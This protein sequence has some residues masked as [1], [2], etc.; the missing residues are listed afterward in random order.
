MSQQWRLAIVIDADG[1]T[2]VQAID[3][4]SGSTRDLSAAQAGAARSSAAMSAASRRVEGDLQGLA[5]TARGLAT[6]F[7]AVW[8]AQTVRDILSTTTRIDGMRRTLEGVLGGS[9]QAAQGIAFV[10][11]EASR[12]GVAFDSS[13]AGYTRLAAAAK[14]TALSGEVDKLASAVIQAGRAFNLS[15]DEISGALT[16]IEQ[17]ISKGTVSAEELRGQLGERLVGSFQVAAQAMGGTTAELSK[18]LETGQVVAEDFLPKFA[19]ALSASTAAAAGLN[20]S[21]PAAEFARVRNELQEMSTQL[22]AGIFEGLGDGLSDLVTKLQQLNATEIGRGIGEFLGALAANADL[23]LVAIVALVGARGIGALITALAGLRTYLAATALWSGWTAGVTGASGALTLLATRAGALVGLLGGIPGVIALVVTGLYALATA[24]SAAEERAAALN[25]TIQE[26]QAASRNGAQSLSAA[27]A[28]ASAAQMREL[29]QRLQREQERMAYQQSVGSVPGVDLARQRI[30]EIRKEMTQLQAAALPVLQQ[31]AQGFADAAGKASVAVTGSQQFAKAQEAV[32]AALVASGVPMGDQIKRAQSLQEVLD[33]LYQAEQ[34]YP[35][36]AALIRDARAQVIA[37]YQREQAETAK[38]STSQRQLTESTIALAAA[39]RRLQE[40]S[41]PL[42]AAL[43]AAEQTSARVAR[44][45]GELAA[46]MGGSYERVRQQYVQ[47]LRSI[48]AGMR[49][50]LSVGPPTAGVQSRLN[51]MEASLQALARLRDQGLLNEWRRTFSGADDVLSGRVNLRSRGRFGNVFGADGETDQ[52]INSW[53][54]LLEAAVER[55]FNSANISDWWR[56]IEEGI[57]QAI[58]QGGAQGF[59]Q[60][61]N[62]MAQTLNTAVNAYRQAGGG[63]RGVTNAAANLPIPYVQQAAQFAMAIDNIFGGRLFGTSWEA[64]AR[65]RN[66]SFGAG[67]ITGSDRITESRQRSLFRGRQTRTRNTALDAQTQGEINALF[68]QLQSSLSLAARRAGA[69]TA[70]L[71]AGAFRQSFD[72][73]GNLVSQVF[74]VAGR[75]YAEDLQ[76]GAQ[77]LL[78]ESII[79][80]LDG[81]DAGVSE[82]VERA[83]TSADELMGVASALL[84]AQEDIRRGSGLLAEGGLAQV[85]TLLLDL[86]APGEE[87]AATYAR[88]VGSTQLLSEALGVMDGSLQ[89]ATTGFVEFSAGVVE[90][91]GGLEAARTQINQILD[92]FFSQAERSAF[93]IADAQARAQREMATLGISGVTFGNFRQRFDEA[94]AAGLT[95]DQFAA[96]VRLGASLADANDAAYETIE[97]LGTLSGSARDAGDATADLARELEAYAAFSAQLGTDL[98]A[99]RANGLD[100][101]AASVTD[102]ERRMRDQIEEANRLARAAGLSG[103][104][105]EDLAAIQEM[106]ALS[107]GQLAAELEASIQSAISDLYGLADAVEELGV[108]SSEI[109]LISRGLGQST[110]QI[111]PARLQRALDIAKQLFQLS[112]ITGDGALDLG[113]R[114]GLPFDRFVADL[115][116]D[117]ARLNDA[118][119]FDRLVAGARTLGVELPEFADRLGV[120]IGALSDRTSGLNDAFERTMG[121]LSADQRATIEP[122]LRRLEGAAPGDRAGIMGEIE[123]AVAALPANLRNLFAPFLDGIDT[124]PL[125]EAAL[126][127]SARIQTAIEIGNGYLNRILGVL[128]LRNPDAPILKPGQDGSGGGGK[129]AGDVGAVAAAIDRA[130]QGHSTLLQ[131]Q[132]AATRAVESAVRQVSADVRALAGDQ[133]RS[134]EKIA[135]AGVPLK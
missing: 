23:A 55:A 70:T 77:R 116:I 99:L 132:I 5:N 69:S 106:F 54:Q 60:V 92:T 48:E 85:A 72:S 41:A 46:S 113:A 65:Q 44:A 28:E 89:R 105:T 1:R 81:L 3:R 125:D 2:A 74:T 123:A 127:Q 56:Q 134:S 120:S 130:A 129:S 76:T 25:R 104:S 103:A 94:R 27:S 88:L 80:M 119:N 98:D 20:A 33:A 83:R 43:R 40:E 131:Q 36:A 64:R 101:F 78:A 26:L 59:L 90:S 42:V 73:K 50:L 37:G 16:A 107:M 124:T 87:L 95:P 121:R 102:I 10:R 114:L 96:W 19:A 39:K 52:Q 71:A 128:S 86:Q 117:L 34:K 31:F 49:A 45:N 118:V 7:A 32:A 122:L 112:F 13:L 24:S 63:A 53:G 67:G 84:L 22:G 66:L 115:G 35:A 57:R 61:A 68:G 21:G 82:A 75:Q 111:D 91:L 135:R 100:P 109:D 79:G 108:Y 8:G 47:D 12:L 9:E 17:M 93:R 126:E 11:A 58:E 29:V 18:M 97:S 15:G 6:V 51:E 14:G 62:G 30:S 38:T 110:Q 133:R 4:V